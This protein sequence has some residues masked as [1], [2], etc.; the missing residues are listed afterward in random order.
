MITRI[1]RLSIQEEEAAEFLKIFKETYNAIRFSEG[2]HELR[3]YRDINQPT[4]FITFSKWE[5]EG[6]LNLYRQSALFRS[7][8]STVK[9]MFKD[10]PVAFSMS[11]EY[12][13]Q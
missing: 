4:I 1:V 8:W 5:S 7:T 10:S 13:S 6:A 11:E 12:P 2:C 3:L 9:K